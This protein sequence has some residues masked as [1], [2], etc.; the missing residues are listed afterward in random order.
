MISVGHMLTGQLWIVA[1]GD[2]ARKHFTLCIVNSKTFC[3]SGKITLDHL[4]TNTN[5]ILMRCQEHFFS[6]FQ[7]CTVI[8]I[9]FSTNMALIANSIKLLSDKSKGSAVCSKALSVSSCLR[10][11]AL[12]GSTIPCLTLVANT[13]PYLPYPTL[14]RPPYPILPTLTYHPSTLN[15]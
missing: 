3:V 6:F 7:D 2:C 14:P 9:L 10:A 1:G 8:V 13:L 15:Q 4:N 5:A 11:T 12:C